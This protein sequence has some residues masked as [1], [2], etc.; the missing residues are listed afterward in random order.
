[1]SSPNDSR[2]QIT[3]DQRGKVCRGEETC[4]PERNRPLQTSTYRQKIILK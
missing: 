3:G 2:D 4:I 1:M